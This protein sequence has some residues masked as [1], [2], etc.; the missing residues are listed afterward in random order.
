MWDALI[1]HF[2]RL[3]F[4]VKLLTLVLPTLSLIIVI[5]LWI[6]FSPYSLR[7]SSFR[8]QPYQQSGENIA[9][10]DDARSTSERAEFFVEVHFNLWSRHQ[11]DIH[12]IDM[13]YEVKGAS[14]GRQT[15]VF[16]NGEEE[17]MDA[18]Y[19][20]KF[21]RKVPQSHVINIWLSR[22]FQCHPSWLD[23]YS[24]VMILFELASSDWE[25]LKTVSI[26][27]KL[28]PGGKL[29]ELEVQVH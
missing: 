18:N 11:L 5:I 7:S 13:R 16:D 19:H 26:N 1:D 27:G 23:Y 20:M 22:R 3:P 24:K 17:Q 4:W 6:A 21:P 8:V 25:G 15:I 9:Q 12:N 10:R 14:P 29:Q 2:T 28:A